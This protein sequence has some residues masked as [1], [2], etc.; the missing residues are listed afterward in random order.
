MGLVLPDPEGEFARI[1]SRRVDQDE[2]LVNNTGE[3]TTQQI[4]QVVLLDM[5][6]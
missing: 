6:P 3:A 4:R 5:L 2:L 1:R